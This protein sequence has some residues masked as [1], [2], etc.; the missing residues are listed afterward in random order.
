ME[1]DPIPQPPRRAFTPQGTRLERHP[2][3]C[4][5][6]ILSLYPFLMQL[7][8][9]NVHW[10]PHPSVTCPPPPSTPMDSAPDSGAG[11]YHPSLSWTA[12][13]VPTPSPLPTTTFCPVP[14]SGC[15]SGRHG[16]LLKNHRWLLK[17]MIPALM[18]KVPNQSSQE[19]Y[20]WQVSLVLFFGQRSFP[21]MQL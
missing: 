6:P 20:F 7:N 3:G 9:E 4:H 10:T 5:H 8:P 18:L 16:W 19:I 12:A 14:S 17:N 15:K 2:Q 1:G 13:S 21:K 11:S